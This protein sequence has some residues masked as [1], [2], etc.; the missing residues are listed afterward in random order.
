MSHA[1]QSKMI[2]H[3]SEKTD[4]GMEGR[5]RV[6]SWKTSQTPSTAYRAP[7]D[8]VLQ[9]VA[10]TRVASKCNLLSQTFVQPEDNSIPKQ[11]R[12]VQA[13]Q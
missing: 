1:E 13:N 10:R 2:D 5:G 6:R 3:S 8:R 7:R 9:L 11:E 4:C 12:Y